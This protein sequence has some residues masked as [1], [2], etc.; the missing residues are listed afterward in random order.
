MRVEACVEQ[1]YVYAYVVSTPL[2]SAFEHRGHAAFAS[3]CLQVF[4]RA[5]VFGCRFS[6]NNLQVTDASEFRQDLILNAVGEVGIV[7]VTAQIVE[8]ENRDAFIQ[9]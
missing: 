7:W 1:L 8:W 9:R 5:F 4:R 2:H 6:R 3:H